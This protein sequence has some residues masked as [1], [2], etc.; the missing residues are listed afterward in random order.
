MTEGNYLLLESGDW[1][2]VA[3]LLDEVWW[4]ALDGDVRVSR[5][6][7]RH[8]EAGRGADDATE[9][10]MRSDEANARDVEGGAARADVVLVDG[11]VVR[12][13]DS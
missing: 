9:W 10:V 2:G 1:A 13:G 5:L 7:A 4:C 6:V 11:V 12:E 8:V 3:P